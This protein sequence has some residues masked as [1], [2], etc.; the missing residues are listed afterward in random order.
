MIVQ[1]LSDYGIVEKIVGGCCQLR[2]DVH[3]EIA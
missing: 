1:T 3:S 2:R